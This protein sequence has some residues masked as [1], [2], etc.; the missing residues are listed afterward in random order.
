[1][2]RW[3]FQQLSLPS[4]LRLDM[5]NIAT[6][7]VSLAKIRCQVLN[8]PFGLHFVV[9]RIESTLTLLVMVLACSD[10]FSPASLWPLVSFTVTGISA[11]SASEAPSRPFSFIDHTL[12][13]A[14]VLPSFSKLEL[15]HHSASPHLSLMSHGGTPADP[16]ATA[17]N[18]EG[19]G[20]ARPSTTSAA[21]EAVTAH[22]CG[23]AYSHAS[24]HAVLVYLGSSSS[25]GCQ[26]S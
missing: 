10:S 14:C 17:Q 19:V 23:H 1:M 16:S 26:A 2:L 22:Q 5:R 12:V 6:D 7:A 20:R 13:T 21:R 25:A 8:L 9:V 24:R 4:P 15:D 3:R 18:L 11:P